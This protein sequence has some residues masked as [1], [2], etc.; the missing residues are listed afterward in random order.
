VSARRADPPQLVGNARM[1]SVER[2]T[3]NAWRALLAWIA[4]TA[5]VAL[6]YV[7]HPPPA[8]LETLWRRP[9]LGCTLMCGYPWATWNAARGPRP[10]ILA[11]PVPCEPG[12]RAAYRT[13]LVARADSAIATLDDLRTRR[14]AYTTPQSQSGYQA[15]RALLADRVER[16][17][18]RFFESTVGPLVTPRRVVHAVVTGEADAGPL[19]SYWLELLRK[20][21]PDTAERL[22]EVASTDWTPMPMFVAGGRVEPDVREQLAR[23]L[24]AAGSAHELTDVRST[25]ALSGFVRP[26]PRSYAVLAERAR[27]ADALGYPVLQ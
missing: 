20:H 21:E 19:D 6:R 15:V 2:T 16:P 4:D 12:G 10:V 24:V 23:A 5:Q 26:D 22:R 11:A 8:A 13:T 25:L 1:Y 3:A 17:A 27:A 14:F 18:A 7:D 9:D